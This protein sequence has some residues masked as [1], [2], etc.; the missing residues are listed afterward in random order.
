MASWPTSLPDISLS[1]T[2]A[3]QDGAIRTPMG[4]GPAKMRR[5]FSA[6]SRY[7]EGSVILDNTERATF[8]TF[9]ATTLAEGSLAFDMDDPRDGTT[10]SWRF[11][12][13]PSFVARK[14]NGSNV[15]TLW[16]ATLSLE[17]LP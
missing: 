15:V 17:I 11:T 2:D 14:G 7:V 4:T 10:Q 8:D 13:P 6:V 9:F 3:R 1:L 16:V 5:R 12:A